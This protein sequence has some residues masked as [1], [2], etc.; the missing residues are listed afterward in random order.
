[1]SSA[2]VEMSMEDP[3]LVVY[4]APKR[5]RW[6]ALRR[7]HVTSTDMAPVCGMPKYGRTRFTVWAEKR[8]QLDD[9]FEENERSEVGRFLENAIAK[10]VAER[11]E[12]RIL[13]LAD[14]MSRGPLGASFD[15]E[16]VD[17]GNVHHGW[18]VEIKNVDR[19]IFK[20]QWTEEGPPD[21]ISVQIQTQLEVSRRPATIL[22]ALVGGNDL[23]IFK[24]RRDP[25]MG[26][27]LR[28]IAEKF[29]RDVEAGIEPDVVADDAE[30]VARL[31]HPREG[32]VLDL[33]HDLEVADWVREYRELG[34]QIKVAEDRRK[35]IKAEILLQAKE[36]SKVLCTGGYTVDTGFTKGSPGTIVTPEMVGT[37][38]G[39][40]EGYRRFVVRAGK[41]AK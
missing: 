4:T 11:M 17:P 14:F 31:F 38:I 15:Y 34:E 7:N 36:A 22:A 23:R 18:L 41:G 26:K 10:L 21:H 24:I 6:L 20:D 9:A 5:E 37:A 12:T 35:L 1:M 3:E 8:G 27:A 16:V 13:R 32:E 33:T 2:E 29:W 28:D 19:M 25:E 40:R 30:A 39:A